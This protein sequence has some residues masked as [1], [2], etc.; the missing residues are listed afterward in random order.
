MPRHEKVRDPLTITYAVG[1]RVKND[2]SDERR[3]DEKRRARM[4]QEETAR[5]NKITLKED[6]V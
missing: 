4:L 1:T 5:E 2:S 6:F 3:D